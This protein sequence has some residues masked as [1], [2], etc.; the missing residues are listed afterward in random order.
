MVNPESKSA[1]AEVTERKVG[2]IGE[3]NFDY[4]RF[5]YTWEAQPGEWLFE[6]RQNNRLLLQKRFDVQL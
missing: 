2:A 1:F 5:E 3:T 4:Y 6:V